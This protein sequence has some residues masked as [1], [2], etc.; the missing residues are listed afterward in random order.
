MLDVKKM[1]AFERYIVSQPHMEYYRAV[2]HFSNLWDGKTSLKGKTVICYCGMGFG[3]IIQGLRYLSIFD[4]QECELILHIPEPLMPLMANKYKCIARENPELPV[5]DYHV[6]LLSLPYLVDFKVSSE[7]YIHVNEMENLAEFADKLK[8]G[9]CWECSGHFEDNIKR[10]VPL[11]YFNVLV[12]PDREFF[13]ICDKIHRPYLMEGAELDFNVLPL[14]N[15]KDTAKLLNALDVVVTADTSVLHLA[16]AM[17]QLTYGLI[18]PSGADLRWDVAEWYSTVSLIRA[19]D[20]NWQLALEKVAEKLLLHDKMII[21][22]P[23]Y[24]GMMP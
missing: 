18:S 20:E 4:E 24:R 14:R 16:G 12:K 23:E 3:D 1:P 9:I 8:V 13:L 10:C 21:P 19:V 7:P 11:K 17:G 22:T 5:H 6:S 2:Y 15:F